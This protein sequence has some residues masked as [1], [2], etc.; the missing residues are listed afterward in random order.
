MTYN[1]KQTD[2]VALLAVF[3]FIAASLGSQDFARAGLI[4]YWPFDSN[5]KSDVNNVWDGTQLGAGVSITNTVGEFVR[6]TGSLKIDDDTISTNYVDV[7]GDIVGTSPVVRTVVAWYKYSDISSNGSYTRNF[8]YETTP[9]FSLSFAI[10]DDGT[11]TNKHVQWYFETPSGNLNNIAADGPVVDNND[12]HHLAMV[13]NKTAGHVRFYHDG[14]IWDEVPI[15]ETMELKLNQTGF[16]IGNHRTGDG[17]RNWDGYIDD[18]AVYDVELR[19]NQIA[20]LYSGQFQ[21]Q[22]VDPNNVLGVVLNLKA[23]DPVPISGARNVPPDGAD[24]SWTSGDY[25]DTHNV[26]LG[27]NFNE[28]NDANASDLTG[29]YRDNQPLDFYH[30][31]PCGCRF[32]LGRT[33]YWRIDEV[34]DTCAPGLW[35]GEVWNF[36]I[37]APY[38]VGNL[39]RAC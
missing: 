23:V 5:Y 10:R 36:T 15:P 7:T 32:P 19:A 30:Y 4:A 25:A 12:W 13:W 22:P 39:N 34:N 35:K 3:A 17:T 16:K 21:G 11:L 6:G 18:M 31:D 20:A 2:F 33:Y 14:T 1:A 9:N 8:V 37:S 27:T 24:L 28:V 38:R 26:Y 29:I